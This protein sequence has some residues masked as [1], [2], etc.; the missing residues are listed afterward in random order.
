MPTQTLSPSSSPS[1]APKTSAP[2]CAPT[3]VPTASPSTLTPSTVSPTESP[4]TLSPTYAPTTIS[5]TTL[6]PSASVESDISINATFTAF[7]YFSVNDGNKAVF[8]SD[9]ELAL[10]ISESPPLSDV[11]IL[12]IYPGT[13]GATIVISSATAGNLNQALS[14]VA[15]LTT[16]PEAV[17]STQNSFDVATYG[18][19]QVSASTATPSPTTMAP[20]NSPVTVS[21]TSSPVTLSPTSQYPEPSA[22]R[23]RDDKAAIT[24]FTSFATTSPLSSNCGELLTAQ[25]ISII[26]TAPTCIWENPSN[27]TI[28]FGAGATLVPGDQ[29]TF[30][31]NSLPRF[32]DGASLPV[33]ASVIVSGPL[34]PQGFNVQTR[35]NATIDW[36]D[37]TAIFVAV[38]DL[39]T[40][41]EFQY[42]WTYTPGINVLGDT[43]KLQ[44]WL[45]D[46]G[47]TSRLMIP[48]ALTSDGSHTLHVQVTDWLGIQSFASTIMNVSI[49][50]VVRFNVPTVFTINRDERLTI[51]ADVAP[52]ACAGVSTLFSKQITQP[53]REY[54][55]SQ[56]F[57]SGASS[58]VVAIPEPNSL[59]LSLPANTLNIGETFAFQFQ[60]KL[61]D[62]ADN[63]VR[64]MGTTI[65]RVQVTAEDVMAQIYGGEG[66]E[67]TAGTFAG[68][69]TDV[70]Q[71]DASGSYD[72]ASPTASLSYAWTVANTNNGGQA[73]ALS[74][75]TDSKLTI[76]SSVLDAGATYRVQVKVT[77][78]IVIQGGSTR[79]GTATQTLT[80]L[81]RRVP[82]LSPL[83][84]IASRVNADDAFS[85][86]MTSTNYA[87]DALTYQWSVVSGST[88]AL[89]VRNLLLGPSTKDLVFKPGVLLPGNAY[90]FL[91]T[92]RNSVGSSGSISIMVNINSGPSGGACA[93]SP[94]NGY[95]LSTL[96]TLSC[97]SWTDAEGDFPLTY[98]FQANLNSG[99][100]GATEFVSVASPTQVESIAA[101]LPPVA[102]TSSNNLGT[103]RL[104]AIVTDSLGSEAR[105]TFSVRVRNSQS[106]S[107]L[108]D[109]STLTAE[110]TTLINAGNVLVSVPLLSTSL[111]LLAAD[112]TSPESDRLA[113]LTD[114]MTTTVSVLSK[115]TT[116]KDLEALQSSIR[117]LGQATQVAA[118]AG[119]AFTLT[120]VTQLQ[121]A[122]E[123]IVKSTNILGSGDVSQD[124][125]TRALDFLSE[126]IIP[127]ARDTE[128]IDAVFSKD[129]ATRA[130][131]ALLDLGTQL[132]LGLDSVPNLKR[133]L[134]DGGVV[135]SAKR[136]SAADAGSGGGSLFTTA[137]GAGIKIPAPLAQ[138]QSSGLDLVLIV[139]NSSSSFLPGSEAFSGG[140]T[141]V[142]I[143]TPGALDGTPLSGINPSFEIIMPLG[144]SVEESQ[145]ETKEFVCKF[146]DTVSS[147]WSTAGVEF[148]ELTTTETG[149]A[150]A[151]CA[152]SH[153]TAFGVE[154]TT[155][156]VVVDPTDSGVDDEE[157]QSDAFFIFC[158]ALFCFNLAAL[159]CLCCCCTARKNLA[160]HN[161]FWRDA[162][163]RSDNLIRAHRGWNIMRE[164]VM[165]S[166]RYQHTWGAIL[167]HKRGDFHG[168]WKRFMIL[169]THLLI[170]A[171]VGGLVYKLLIDTAV[172]AVLTVLLT[173]PVPLML[174]GLMNRNA[175]AEFQTVL[176]ANEMGP[177]D[178]F[179]TFFAALVGATTFHLSDD[180]E[181]LGDKNNDDNTYYGISNAEA[182]GRIED[183]N[184]LKKE[185]NNGF[186]AVAVELE[187]SDTTNSLKP[188]IST[189]PKETPAKSKVPRRSSILRT[190]RYLENDSHQDVSVT[191]EQV[192]MKSK[193]APAMDDIR[194][195]NPTYGRSRDVFKVSNKDM[196][197][198][199]SP[200]GRIVCC[201]LFY[202]KANSNY[203]Y[204]VMDAF[205][206]AL[207]IGTSLIALITVA[208][209]LRGL[210]LAAVV[211]AII[212]FVLD[213]V[214]R[215]IFPVI[216]YLALY[217]PLGC[218]GRD[219]KGLLRN[220]ANAS[221]Q[222]IK[223]ESKEAKTS[224]MPPR[225]SSAPT[226]PPPPQVIPKEDFRAESERPFGSEKVIQVAFKAGSLGFKFK[227]MVISK[228]YPGMQA[229][230]K[231]CK[232]GWAIIAVNGQE[233]ESDKH[234]YKM[235]Q[236]CHRKFEMFIVTF[237]PRPPRPRA[238]GQRQHS[239][240]GSAYGSR[241]RSIVASRR[242]SRG[243]GG[244][245]AGQ[246]N[247][248]LSSALD[249]AER[250]SRRR[251]SKSVR[252]SIPDIESQNMPSPRSFRVVTP[253]DLSPNDSNSDVPIPTGSDEK[254]KGPNIALSDDY[255]AKRGQGGG[256]H[257][258][259][260]PPKTAVAGMQISTGQHI[261][262]GTRRPNPVEIK[263]GKYQG[264]ASRPSESAHQPS[265]PR[266]NESKPTSN[267][268]LDPGANKT[269]KDGKG[270]ADI[271]ALKQTSTTRVSD[272]D[273]EKKQS[274]PTSGGRSDKS[275]N[276]AVQP[277][278]NKAH[279]SLKEADGD[280]SSSDYSSGDE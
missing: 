131:E 267:P 206:L 83:S 54:T 2:S 123:L 4:T 122:V 200:Q 51:L 240:Q 251:R 199:L 129:L 42:R 62:P 45:A 23:V 270:I 145:Q 223:V 30:L 104:R 14:V 259:S 142:E 25:T 1:A 101:T 78:D 58:T 147:T 171:T 132:L 108:S 125:L 234:L 36:C 160:S 221:M 168:S 61:L 198:A 16:T 137:S 113:A 66:A 77:S 196:V 84:E 261:R 87:D 130:E 140:M 255:D 18:V 174:K 95:A 156:N 64:G 76:L 28:Y 7:N 96:F 94:S 183:D 203:D 225:V 74:S 136:V 167:T 128:V 194:T 186:S 256:G 235:L 40:D 10:R 218:K 32:P 232:A 180:V 276:S 19:P 80:I 212:A 126:V 209:L 85:V 257:A 279:I 70:I 46:N 227:R 187:P 214:F 275:A 67:I 110:S 75:T 35:G 90:E 273:T 277:S 205:V 170:M 65:I 185:K 50:P 178:R 121:D 102:G 253:G 26:G 215:L 166:I 260:M 226:R 265:E 114:I 27:L 210:G 201:H 152:S 37:E 9:Y 191:M 63:T 93:A 246:D 118:D 22:A 220:H 49:G 237:I 233:P 217:A 38:P 244:S 98:T 258:A 150:A 236:R 163:Q 55:W 157:A 176:A 79:E 24:V 115:A 82:I 31:A 161:A 222:S 43:T 99:T 13:D 250:R 197:V 33:Q 47:N 271:A 207:C 69:N 238:S 53:L 141:V 88:S 249:K 5:P 243:D 262:A 117:L 202:D 11:Q 133:E 59:Q 12:R 188:M 153:L 111:L 120:Q 20:T 135:V 116:M 89:E 208:A 21:P 162:K 149:E 193:A 229:D 242:A 103:L 239:R 119:L 278:A 138:F 107:S 190:S 97:S 165:K 182:K 195:S 274:Q 127:T 164:S 86:Q 100:N 15:Q 143:R 72:P 3:R 213:I 241:I 266:D 204:T 71:F 159:P 280:S 134:S 144:I 57:V 254:S 91:L 151:L 52:A 264:I 268:N 252:F 173:L 39:D 81:N 68:A 216:Y 146:Y 105:F 34:S 189:N 230:S 219:L 181:P 228:V 73:V 158:L 148:L 172:A 60:A 92:A 247:E 179:Y 269:D 184:S 106:L 17:F 8:E 231:G 139:A 248:V 177:M 245:W 154:I 41:R 112:A 175:P 272:D 124:V 56:A 224:S 263:N 169:S 29:I 48:I 44:N 109:I 6:A 192:D 211:V 155:G